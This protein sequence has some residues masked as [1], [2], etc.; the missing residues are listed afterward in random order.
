MEE[1]LKNRSPI[2]IPAL[3]EEMKAL[4]A[5]LEELKRKEEEQSKRE[6]QDVREQKVKDDLNRRRSSVHF[7]TNAPS[8]REAGKP[9]S[10]VVSQEDFGAVDA[11]GDGKISRDEWRLWADAEITFLEQANKDKMEI[12]AENKRLRQALTKPSLSQ[13]EEFL[14]V[15]D[16]EMA[17][18]ND[19]AVEMQFLQDQ[20]E[21]ELAIS[22]NA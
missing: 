21:A 8:T 14:Q 15:Q 5:E 18:L 3:D 20:L 13:Q 7:D 16:L 6:E 4:R 9:F 17:E 19:Q 22:L 12:M 11:D 1:F 10:S 2:D